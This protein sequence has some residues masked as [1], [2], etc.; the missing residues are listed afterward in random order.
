MYL[1]DHRFTTYSEHDGVSQATANE[2]TVQTAQFRYLL[3]YMKTITRRHAGLKKQ[4]GQPFTYTLIL[5]QKHALQA[6]V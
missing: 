3:M 1:L 5:H 2:T 4:A 6:D